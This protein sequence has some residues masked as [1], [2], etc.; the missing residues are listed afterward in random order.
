MRR[1]LLLCSIGML[2]AILFILAGCGDSLGTSTPQ[3]LSGVSNPPIH[4]NLTRAGVSYT[5]AQ[6]RH[7]YGFDQLAGNGAGQTIAIVDAYGSPTIQN[8][9][10]TFCS[11][12]GLPTTTITIAYPTGKPKKT[13]GGWALETA[14]DVEWAHAIA[15]GASILLVV[16]KSNSNSDLLAAV[17]YAAQR[18]QQV[19][20]SWGGSEWSTSTAQDYHFN[21]P[22][23]TFF[24][25]SGDNGAGVEWPAVSKYV[26]GVGG[27]SL[28]LDG[29][30]NRS[31]EPAWSGSGGGQ[32]RYVSEPSFQTVWQSSGKRQVPDVSYNADP[33]TGF[34]VYDGTPYGRSK[35]GWYVVGGTSAGAPQWAAVM[36]LVNAG[37]SSGLSAA[38]NAIYTLGSPSNYLSDFVD[39]ISGSNGYAATTG[40]DLATGIGSPLAQ[41]LV[42][43]LAAY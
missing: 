43:G 29:A 3:Q 34:R 1:F 14:L 18:A 23:V 11:N 31:S 26:V 22:G 6:I 19:S 32:S 24:A 41:T 8:D 15:P 12:F 28:Y 36:A 42:P 4:V 13:D 25:S 16:A 33:N 40:Y 2:P 38:N 5:P 35:A 17:D 7:A 20:M 9:L 30:N 21:V 27:T 37:R 39:I 10:N